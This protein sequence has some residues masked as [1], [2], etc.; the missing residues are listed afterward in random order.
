[1]SSPASCS[2]CDIEGDVRACEQ[3][4]SQAWKNITAAFE[5][6]KGGSTSAGGDFKFNTDTTAVRQGVKDIGYALKDIAK[7]VS[8]CHLQELAEILA[9]LGV[10]L[11]L[12]PEVSWIEEILHIIIEGVDIENEL[13]NACV[14]YSAGNWVGFGYNVAKLTKT[15]ATVEVPAEAVAQV[16]GR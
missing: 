3:D 6:F 8:D 12:A 9:A 16:L 7:G 15:L 13:G 10:K 14:D 4:F 1:M 5:Q 2:S 11:G